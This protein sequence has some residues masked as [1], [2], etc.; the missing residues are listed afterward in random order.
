MLRGGLLRRCLLSAAVRWKT[1]AAG[2]LA[3]Y[4]ALVASREIHFDTHQMAAVKQLQVLY[5]DIV[6]IPHT[7]A[8]VA[9]PVVSN[10]PPPPSNGNMWSS[11]FSTFTSPSSTSTPAPST[12]LT[13]STVPIRGV[14]LWGGVGCGKT[15]LMDLF[16]SSLTSLPKTTSLRV[17][18]HSFMIDVHK[19]LHRHKHSSSSRGSA[20]LEV[21][22]DELLREG[23]ASAGS[24]RQVICFDEFQ[25]TDIADA[26][27]LRSLFS[28]LFSRGVIIVATSNR[29][30]EQLYLHGLQ[31]HLFL[32]FIDL[33]VERTAVVAMDES[34]TDYRQVL[35][36]ASGDSK[37]VHASFLVYLICH[38]G[39]CPA[40]PLALIAFQHISLSII[41]PEPLI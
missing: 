7:A 13:S 9:P 23:N 18:F 34:S 21:V 10:H 26:L 29:P 37:V 11:F 8:A 27:I 32:P 1:S 14:Y 31:R 39:H 17:H 3:E 28:H 16:H 4:E 6:R 22:A 30:P 12:P 24:S 36:A 38:A 40:L 25:V 15:F 5:D 2:P 19:R 41:N 20:A 33:L 35:A